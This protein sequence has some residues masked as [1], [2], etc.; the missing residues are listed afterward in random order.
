[1]HSSKEVL[2]T[3]SSVLVRGILKSSRDV[4]LGR[5][6]KHSVS[7]IEVP[8]LFQ[9]LT[10]VQRESEPKEFSEGGLRMKHSSF[11]MVRALYFL[12]EPNENVQAQHESL[13]CYSTIIHT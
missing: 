9:E 7:F 1:M 5:R 3:G 13:Q 11:D 12:R 8:C 4:L 2:I 10:I 6:S